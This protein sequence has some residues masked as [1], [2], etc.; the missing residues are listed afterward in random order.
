MDMT[1]SAVKKMPRWAQIVSD[2]C[3]PLLLPTYAMALAMWITPLRVLP[4]SNRLVATAMVAVLTALVPCLAIM[5]LFRLG[6]VSDRALSNR[7]QRILPFS[8][9]IVC[10]GCAAWMLHGIGAP[11]W[12]SMFFAGGAAACL[13][14][15][16]IT[17]W[18]K[19]SAHAT[20]AGG[21]TGMVTWFA[22]SG[23]ADIGA[24]LWLSGVILLSGLI[25]SA[26]IE[27]GRHT[28]AQVAAG[29]F[30]GLA[31][32]FGLMCIH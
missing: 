8:F 12:L 7:R 22:V 14:D 1:D 23:L 27:L 24:M 2:V 29:F 10:Y 21:M 13:V 18:W 17:L 5:I 19:I 15:M 6:K 31:A 26:R 11:M 16:I 30:V 9:V 32:T 25:G 20:A 4:E 3:S 28:F